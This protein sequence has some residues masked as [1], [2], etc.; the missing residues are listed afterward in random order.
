[1]SPRQAQLLADEWAALEVEPLRTKVD[2]PEDVFA[3]QCR[4]YQLP[5]F[6]QQL[7]FAKAELG[8]QWRFDFAWRDYWL[9]VE[10]EGL[11]PR[12]IGR[13][14]V[15]GGRHGSI[16]GIKGDMQKYNTAA[17]LGWTVLRFEQNDVKPRRAIEFTMRVLAARGWRQEGQT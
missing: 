14:I 15:A 8:R 3:S 16:A 9:A 6:E 10:I 11:V 7:M 1:M 4:S 13:E 2:G 5:P 12:K 17:L